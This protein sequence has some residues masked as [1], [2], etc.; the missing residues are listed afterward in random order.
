VVGAAVRHLR[1][2]AGTAVLRH[3]SVV[4][5]VSEEQR[6][7]PPTYRREIVY[8]RETR[9]FAMCLDGELVGFA[10][11]YDEAQATLA[12]LVFQLQSGAFFRQS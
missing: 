10:R 2:A 3:V 11:T 1:Q 12:E 5:A 7:A 6:P 8:D 4:S 9:D